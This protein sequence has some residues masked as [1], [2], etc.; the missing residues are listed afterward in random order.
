MSYELGKIF[1]Q[2][3]IVMILRFA[4]FVIRLVVKRKRVVLLLYAA[5]VQDV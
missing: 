3:E 4:A 5:S 2:L 1:L